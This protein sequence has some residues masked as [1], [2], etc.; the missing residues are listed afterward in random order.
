M[1]NKIRTH[2][3]SA[4]IIGTLLLAL[5]SATAQP[6]TFTRPYQGRQTDLN[7]GHKIIPTQDGNYVIAGNWNNEGYLMKVNCKGD[8]MDRK[9]Y[10]GVVGGPYKITDV[11]EL[12]NGDLLVGGQCDHCAT[13]DTTGK[14][15]LFETDPSL[16]YKP[17][18]GVKKFVPPV[19]GP[20]MTTGEAYPNTKLATTSDGFYALSTM[21]CLSD[22]NPTFGCW[23]NEDTYVTKLDNALNLQWHKLLNYKNEFVFHYE[24]DAQNR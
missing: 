6:Y 20:L 12:A 22:V 7:Q 21:H 17:A 10:A 5:S 14:V 13:G 2:K 24:R 3:N 15:L 4:A 11:L 23:N 1:E 16:S 8:S 9:T 19:S 18:H